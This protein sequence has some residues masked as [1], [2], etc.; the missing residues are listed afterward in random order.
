MVSSTRPSWERADIQMFDV[1]PPNDVRGIEA[2][3]A[4]WP[5]SFESFSRGALFELVSLDVTAGADG[6]FATALLRCAN[7][8]GLKKE[9]DLVRLTV[10]LRSEGGRWT[11]RTSTTASRLGD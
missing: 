6:A 11:S 9:P 5:P 10:G 7:E 2:Y 3:R 8:E 1:P 4:T